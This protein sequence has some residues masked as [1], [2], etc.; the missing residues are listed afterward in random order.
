LTVIPL[1]HRAGVEALIDLSH[2]PIMTKVYQRHTLRRHERQV[3]QRA[4]RRPSQT[5]GLDWSSVLESSRPTR[6]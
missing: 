1:P 4:P 2:H 3:E 5:E 6:G